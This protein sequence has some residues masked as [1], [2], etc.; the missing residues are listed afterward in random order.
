MR[1][2]L[3]LKLLAAVMIVAFF[4]PAPIAARAPGLAMTISESPDGV[5]IVYDLPAPVTG[6]AVRGAGQESPPPGTHVRVLESGLSY[7]RGRIEGPAPFRRATL[8]I[9]PDDGDVDS[10][11][12]LLSA[13]AGRGYVLFAPYVLPGGPV[14]ARVSIGGGRLRAL[15]RSEAEGGYVLVGVVPARD[16][17]FRGLA[18]TSTPVSLQAQLYGRTRA[19]LGFYTDRLH[20][21]LA[22]PPILILSAILEPADRGHRFFRGDVTPNGVVFLRF[23]GTGD[24]IADLNSTRQ[25]TSFLAHELFHLWDRRQGDHPMAEAWLH[26]GSAEYFAWRATAALWP[27]QIS[28]DR[29]VEGALGYCSAFLGSRALAGL[30]AAE[31]QTNRYNCGAVL[32]WIVDLGVSTGSR[33]RSDGFTLWAQLLAGGD[34][35]PAQFRAAA[36]AQAPG[37]APLL[38]AFIDSGGNARWRALADFASRAGA[39]VEARAARPAMIRFPAARSIVLSACGAFWGAGDTDVEFYVS[40]P[41]DCAALSGNVTLLRVDG[42]DPMQ[43]QLFHDRV[44]R[45]CGARQSLAM[46]VRSNGT[47]REIALPC[48]V[49]VEDPVPDFHVTRALALSPRARSSP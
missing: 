4:L 39:E 25:F 10:R 19:L 28:L 44:R 12:P 33:G 11:Y 21:R 26:E 24:Q 6:L 13:V 5:R 45:R 1:A 22:R 31:A 2:R 47:T 40:A 32:N 35:N 36:A 9:A 3:A 18:S 8:L 14:A 16:G 43:A 34:Y 48:T 46:T 17:P 29:K 42:T 23:H 15:A 38:D 49:D 37:T 7:R 20:R 30:N 41:T 27:D